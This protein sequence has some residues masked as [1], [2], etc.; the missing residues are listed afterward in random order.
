LWQEIDARMLAT[1]RLKSKLVDLKEEKRKFAALKSD[2]DEVCHCSLQL[3]GV[4]YV[5]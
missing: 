3:I 5:V 1:A 4:G 2:L